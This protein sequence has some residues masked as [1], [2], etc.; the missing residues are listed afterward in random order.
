MEDVPVVC[1]NLYTDRATALNAPLG[2]IH[3]MFCETCG[4]TFNAAFDETKMDYGEN[5]ETSLHYS[6]H[7]QNYA[8]GLAQRLIDTYEL[9][10]KNIVEI[11]CGQAEFLSELCNLGQNKGYGFDQSFD[12]A[13]SDLSA[14]LE[15]LPQNYGPEFRDLHADLFCCRHVLEHVADP[16]SFIQQLKNT[17]SENQESILY[18]EVPN[19]LFTLRDLGIWDLIYEHCSYFWAG[20]LALLFHRC[21]FRVNRVAT[22]YDEQFLAIDLKNTA[23]N[24]RNCKGLEYAF[25]QLAGVASYAHAFSMRY[26]EKKHHWQGLRRDLARDRRPAVIWGAGSKGVTFLNLTGNE[27]QGDRLEFAVDV[28]PRK[29][30]KH[31]PGTGHRIIPPAEL[32]QINP[33]VV[34]LM[35]PAYE[36]EVRGQLSDLGINAE[37]EVV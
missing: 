35:N 16:V 34:F 25:E 29:H 30:G 3:L 8:R 4:H 20:S 18:F 22:A 28:N 7:F 21:D 13:K 10:G 19:G 32:S 1:N 14:Q 9:S 12:P 31:I 24:D 6:E 2:D 15:V 5:Y 23:L 11:G 36:A 27:L 26:R 37:L 17:L 33:E